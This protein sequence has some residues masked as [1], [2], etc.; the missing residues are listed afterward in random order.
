M[1]QHNAEGQLQPL[2]IAVYTE[3]RIC[4]SSFW[5]EPCS[6]SNF[7]FLMHLP[8]LQ[9]GGG[10]DVQQEELLAWLLH[11]RFSEAGFL[12]AEELRSRGHS[13][14]EG[15]S[16][17]LKWS[18]DFLT[19]L[20][21]WVLSCFALTGSGWFPVTEI[22]AIWVLEIGVSLPPLQVEGGVGSLGCKPRSG[23]HLPSWTQLL[24][25]QICCL[26]CLCKCSSTDCENSSNLKGNS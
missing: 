11:W 19:D 9:W 7:T 20:V 23:K 22:L 26:T 17:K 3:L 1:E 8:L 13:F 4:M 14:L 18:K 25:A 5:M 21:T 6:C 12:L 2:S 16:E 24:H 10:E 15:L